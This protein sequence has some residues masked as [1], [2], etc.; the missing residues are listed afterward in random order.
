MAGTFI[1][2][3]VLMTGPRV[4]QGVDNYLECNDQ[5]STLCLTQVR[6]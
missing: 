6:P 3:V 2:C 4:A 5:P 1:G